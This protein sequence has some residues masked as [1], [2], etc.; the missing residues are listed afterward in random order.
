VS[1]T[2]IA[3][4]ASSCIERYDSGS[5]P[6]STVSELGVDGNAALTQASL[7]LAPSSVAVSKVAV[8]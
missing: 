6:A 3:A 7:D 8:C 4:T 1:T 2:A 5:A